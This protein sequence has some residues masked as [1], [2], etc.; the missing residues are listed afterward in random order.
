M[1]A[2]CIRM[3]RAIG[4]TC[5]AL[6]MPASWGLPQNAKRGAAYTLELAD[7]T[8]VLLMRFPYFYEGHLDHNGDFVPDPK[9]PPI[10]CKV[11]QEQRPEWIAALEKRKAPIFNRHRGGLRADVVYQY[12]SG[13]WLIPGELNGEYFMPGI[14]DDQTI[15][16]F[17]IEEYLR[18]YHPERHIRIYNL[19]GR[20]VPRP[21]DAKK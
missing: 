9:A 8:P 7:K 15:K 10:E 4:I 21:K 1:A 13:D 20:I 11:E 16:V 6:M 14:D 12:V 5:L 19:P 2:P 3:R 17:R 18:T